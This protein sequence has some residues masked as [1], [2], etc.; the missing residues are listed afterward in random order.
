[1]NEGFIVNF[2]ENVNVPVKE[3]LKWVNICW[4]YS[5]EYGD[6]LVEESLFGAL[7]ILKLVPAWMISCMFSAMKNVNVEMI[8]MLATTAFELLTS[9]RSM[10]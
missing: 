3:F 7:R 5:Q 4:R 6:I 8:F 1:M 2:S 10:C 9:I